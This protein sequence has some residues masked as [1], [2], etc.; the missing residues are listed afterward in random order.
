MASA[1][2]QY[3]I[4]FS[5]KPTQMVQD[6]SNSGYLHFNGNLF[7]Q[8]TPGTGFTTGTYII[9]VLYLTYSK[10]ELEKGSFRRVQ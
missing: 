8:L 1:I 3:W 9:D 5:D 7:L 10:L 2:P 4:W 6:A